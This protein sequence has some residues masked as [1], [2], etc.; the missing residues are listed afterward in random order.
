MVAK[1]EIVF[2]DSRG[3][4]GLLENVSKQEL[5]S[6]EKIKS[7]ASSMDVS[8]T[9]ED[10]DEAEISITQIKKNTGFVVNEENGQDIFTGVRSAAMG[11]LSSSFWPDD[12]RLE[13]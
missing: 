2:C 1:R 11:K 4:L 12:F 9:N 5:P 13:M 10:D 8:F 6:S 3:Q 7:S